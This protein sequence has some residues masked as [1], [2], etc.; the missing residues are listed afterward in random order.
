MTMYNLLNSK[1]NVFA[2]CIVIESDK[3]NT[4]YSYSTKICTVQNGQITYLDTWYHSLTTQKHLNAFLSLH[5]LP[6][7]SKKE[8]DEMRNK[9]KITN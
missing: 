3:G 9:E 7:I 4:L 6:N 8:L 2:N 1:G 5:N